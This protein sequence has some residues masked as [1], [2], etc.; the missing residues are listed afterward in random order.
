[1]ETD[2]N[3]RAKIRRVE[4]RERI[5][6]Y[7]DECNELNAELEQ[8]LA[9]FGD[10]R[11]KILLTYLKGSDVKTSGENVEKTIVRYEAGIK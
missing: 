9:E 10:K 6:W 2:P 3:K 7:A 5:E 11:F 4:G 1:M 8:E